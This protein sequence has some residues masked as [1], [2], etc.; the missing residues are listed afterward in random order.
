MSNSDK[1]SKGQKVLY[2]GS[3]G[4][5]GNPM[6]VTVKEIVKNYDGEEIILTEELEGYITFND[7][8]TLNMVK[9]LLGGGV[10]DG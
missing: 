10:G 1:L 2:L 3:I 4:C 6:V 9:E 8:L 5:C 7:I